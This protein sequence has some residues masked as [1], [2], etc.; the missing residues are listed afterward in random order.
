MTEIMDGEA[1][2]AGLRDK[3]RSSIETLADHGERPGLATVLMSDDPASQTYVDM[4]QKDCEEVGIEGINVELDPESSPQELYDT[5]DDLN[6]DPDVNGILIQQPLPDYVN[7]RAVIRHVDP[8]KDVEA[9]H[10]ENIGRFVAGYA[11]YRPCTPFGV[12]HLLEEYDIDTQGW[13][14]T[15]VGHSDIVGKPLANLMVQKQ[16][17]PDGSAGEPHATVTICHVET[18]DLAEKTRNADVVIVATGVPELIDGSMISEGTVVI[19]VGINQVEA[20]NEKGYELVGDV[21]FE[22]A[23]EKASYITPVPGGVGAM[24]RAMLLYNTVKA[25]SIQTGIDV[26]LPSFCKGGI[27]PYTPEAQT[28]HPAEPADQ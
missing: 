20:D 26:E 28:H 4:K 24:T 27:P 7:S 2:A 23:K 16:E 19:D 10:P 15:I 11:R 6:A 1:V 17:G 8:I 22:S 21:D 13:D 12:Q 25:T 5:I 9:M 18:Q 14:V 3:L